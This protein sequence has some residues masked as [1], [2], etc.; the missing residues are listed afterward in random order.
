M[1][2]SNP[3]APPAKAPLPYVTIVGATVGLLLPIAAIALLFWSTYT[4]SVDGELSAEAKLRES[5]ATE[6]RQMTTYDWIDKPTAG[7][8][9]VVRIPV[10]R[11]RE[12]ILAET[13]PKKESKQ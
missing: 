9:G 1:T 10:Q 7:K 11:A 4:P 5:Q 12:L 6:E 13:A 2:A 8:S 3:P